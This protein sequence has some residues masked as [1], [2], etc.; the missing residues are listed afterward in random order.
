V[1]VDEAAV[2]R[3]RDVRG[4]DARLVVDEPTQ[5]RRRAAELNE[6][7]HPLCGEEGEVVDGTP[8]DV[9]F[10]RED[11]PEWVEFAAAGG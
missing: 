8:G 1:G 4:G 5:P 7:G 10:R 3:L 11:G 9:G 2:P 6:D